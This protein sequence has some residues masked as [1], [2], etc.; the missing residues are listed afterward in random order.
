MHEQQQHQ[1]QQQLQQN[2]HTQNLQPP[3]QYSNN[4]NQ[5]IAAKKTQH[6]KGQQQQAEPKNQMRFSYVGNLHISVTGNDIYDF[7]GLRSTKY[8]QEISNVDLPLCKKNQGNL[9]DTRF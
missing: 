2:Q 8:F 9:K 6:Q 7:F 3:R 4:N 1:S 5:V